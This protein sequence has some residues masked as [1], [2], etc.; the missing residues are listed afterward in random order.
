MKNSLLIIGGIP[1]RHRPETIGGTTV[2]ME[3]LIQHCDIHGIKY[4]LIPTNKHTGR[5][6]FARNYMSMLYNYIRNISPSSVVMVNISSL[7]GTYL[8]YPILFLIAKLWRKKIV[9]RMFAGNL[10]SYLSCR[11]ILQK[12][13]VFFLKQSDIAFFE[14]KELIEYFNKFKIK[15]AWFPNVRQQKAAPKTEKEMKTYHKKFVFMAHVKKEK[16]IEEL[17]ECFKQLPQEYTVDIYGQLVDYQTKNLQGSNFNYQGILQPQEVFK[18]LKS[19]D[20][21]LLPSYR[22]GYPGIVIE[23]FAMG[24]PVIATSVG[25]IPEIVE[26]GHNGFIIPPKDAVAL[27]KAIKDFDNA[28]HLELSQ[29]ALESF[30]E[31]FDSETV[32][33]RIIKIMFSL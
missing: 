6:A 7:K 13:V 14:T 31:N 33:S 5:L 4:R 20:C 21:L 17:L 10:K 8:I 12:I 27:A 1:Y 18:I 29:N 26:N 28:N 19:Y 2:L 9:F 23:S 30:K 24:I 22:E 3:N 25:G 16:G 11:P 15:N 32:N